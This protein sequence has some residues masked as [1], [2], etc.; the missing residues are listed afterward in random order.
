[1]AS[2]E[3]L[4]GQIS[5]WVWGAPLLILLCGTHLFLT[6][7]LRLIQRF[8]PLAIRLSFGRSREGEGDV[9]QFGALTT[10]KAT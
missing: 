6:F 9:S 1:M 2:A 10:R 3:Q 8:L 7:R 5:D 4:L